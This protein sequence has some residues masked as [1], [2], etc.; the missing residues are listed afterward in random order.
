[1]VQALM[2]SRGVVLIR[3]PCGTRI[4]ASGYVEKSYPSL[5]SI[6]ITPRTPKPFKTFQQV[7][8]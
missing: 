7:L 4:I 6:D 5:K 2:G 1:M 8:Q 3:F